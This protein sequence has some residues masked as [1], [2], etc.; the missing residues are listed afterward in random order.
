MRDR[1]KSRYIVDLPKHLAVCEGNYHRILK[2]MP[3]LQEA[4]DNTSAQQW[5]YA[6]SGFHGDA[7]TKGL[8]LSIVVAEIAKYTTM[9]NVSVTPSATASSDAAVDEPITP[10]NTDNNLLTVL[11]S[12]SLDIRLYHDAQLA[13]VVSSRGCRQ[14]AA[15][16]EYPNQHMHQCDEKAQLNQFL[17]ELIGF[18]LVKGRVAYNVM[19][20]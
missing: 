2:L 12:Y 11:A 16:H 18:C 13:E 6:M 4:R 10:N 8:E 9:L 7:E 3:N 15:R 1:P 19:S 14:F 17:G 20:A 5:L